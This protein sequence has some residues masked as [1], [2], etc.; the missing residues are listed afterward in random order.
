MPNFVETNNF[1][2]KRITAE[3]IG[4]SYGLSEFWLL[5]SFICLFL[6]GSNAFNVR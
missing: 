1:E 4:C 6:S 3:R 5:R 2:V